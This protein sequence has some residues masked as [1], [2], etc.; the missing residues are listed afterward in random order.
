M[1]GLHW[2]RSAQRFWH[3]T[4]TALPTAIRVF[5]VPRARDLSLMGF[6]LFRIAYGTVV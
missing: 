6:D 4:K 2:A 3:G 5:Q 1:N